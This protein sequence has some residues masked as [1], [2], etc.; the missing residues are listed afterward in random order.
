M[1]SYF[2]RFS[3]VEVQKTFYKPTKLET[4][5]RWREKAPRDFVFALKAWQLITHPPTSP[6]YRKAGLK[7]EKPE[8]YGF[9]RP[10][11]E[12]FEAWEVT[13]DIS[14]ALKAEVIVFQCPA[15]FKPTAENISNMLDFFNSIERGGVVLAWE[16]R[17]GWEDSLVRELCLNLDLVHCVDPFIS[18]LAVERDV[19]Y[20]RLH[21]YEGKRPY[22]HEYTSEELRNLLD[23]CL[24]L[25]SSMVYC[26]FNN[27]QMLKNAMEFKELLNYQSSQGLS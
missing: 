14:R 17:G 19:S 16:P 15:S 7:I 25:K 2:K 5:Q 26:L 10:T 6:T 11:E 4:A 9:F 21:G 3:L 23:K 20:L 8:K 13:Q 22:Y 12:V 27:L 1:A 18:N 24:R